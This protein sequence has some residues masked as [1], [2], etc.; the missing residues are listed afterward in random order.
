M[1]SSR[2]ARA[3]SPPRRPA[4]FPAAAPAA[5][6]VP[7]DHAARFEL[8]GTPGH[9]LQD[10]INVSVDGVFVAVAIGY[11]LEEDRGR[12]ARMRPAQNQA[13]GIVPGD[14]TLGEIPVP[15]L[16]DG[17]RLNPAFDRLVF[18]PDDNGSSRSRG[19]VLER[20]LS[21]EPLTPA[22]FT[23]NGDG[24]AALVFERLRPPQTFSFLLSIVD[25]GTGRELQDEPIHSLASLGRSDGERPFRMLAQPLT[26]QPRS[27]V[28]LQV[29]EQSTDVRG[30]LFIVLYG[31]KV[32][33][34]GCA[35]PMPLFARPPADRVIPFDYV[36]TF[37]L[38]GR[39]GHLLEDEVSVNVE[40]GFVATAVGYGLEVD[41]PRVAIEWDNVDAIVDAPQR[42]A[43]QAVRNGLGA[44]G[45]TFDLGALP[46]RLLPTSALQDG[47]RLRPEYLRIAFAGGGGLTD[48][49]PVSL[50]DEIFERLNA[51]EAVSF[52]YSIFDSGRGI[53]LQNQPIHNIAGLGGADG[54]RP[55]KKLLRPMVCVP[56]ST[57]RVR[58]E[59]H[60]GRGTLFL[61]FQGYKRLDGGR[62]GARS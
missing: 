24:D 3:P 13:G 27:T 30:T 45:A 44:A 2:S 15:A 25:S 7:F 5:P 51:P 39:P 40:G 52:R 22:L 31:Y 10:V 54:G 49:L 48:R 21:D 12:P 16:I 57:I 28:R 36:T 33:A 61:V 53:E 43:A 38:T 18:T 42:L 34:S 6:F 11:G 1:V 56:R 4:G 41:S 9:V 19:A 59:E 23:G 32:L 8:T 26:F 55:F 47:I 58:V 17:V 37:R 62:R 50:V 14:V 46:L 20:H 35:E 60:F 29:V